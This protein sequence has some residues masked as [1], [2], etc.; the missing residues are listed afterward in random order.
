[1]SRGTYPPC[2]NKILKQGRTKKTCSKT[3]TRVCYHVPIMTSSSEPRLINHTHRELINKAGA[4]KRRKLS[5]LCEGRTTMSWVLVPEIWFDHKL[6]LLQVYMITN[7]LA[8]F[9][10]YRVWMPDNWFVFDLYYPRVA[11]ILV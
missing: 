6:I 11:N 10:I 7:P 5:S 3:L 9:P 2:L 8:W 1:M 4:T